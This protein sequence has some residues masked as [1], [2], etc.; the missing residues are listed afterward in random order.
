MRAWAPRQSCAAPPGHRLVEEVQ[1][2][3]EHLT[4]IVDGSEVNGV[5]IVKDGIVSVAVV[6]VGQ[7]QVALIDAGNDSAGTAI[8]ADLARRQLG[9]GAVTAIFITHGHQ[10]HTGALPVFPGAQVFALEEEVPVVEGRAG[11]HGPATR[12]MPVRPT[13]V[14]VIRPLRDGETVTIGE[15]QVRVFAVPGHTAGSAAYLVN[16]VLVMGDAADIAGDGKIIGSPW[17][18]SD[19]QAE[20]RASLVRLDRRLLQEQ[21][22]VKAI[23]CAHS[24]VSRK[25]LAPLTAFALIQ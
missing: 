16:G 17:L 11:S 20:D 10:D 23:A 21:T 12:F 5:R 8:L 7:R 18:F 15:T 1:D 22:E 3:L 19:S 13:G 9:A 24:G 25:G 6:P 2:R 14:K 4:A